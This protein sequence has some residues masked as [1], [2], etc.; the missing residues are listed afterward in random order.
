MAILD[1]IKQNY[2]TYLPYANPSFYPDSAAAQSQ[3]DSTQS[4]VDSLDS[5]TL[6]AYNQ[7][8]LPIVFTGS[9]STYQATYDSLASKTDQELRDGV[10]SLVLYYTIKT[11]TVQGPPDLRGDYTLMERF[12]MQAT[13]PSD[14]NLLS[15]TKIK[16]SDPDPVKWPYST[17]GFDFSNQPSISNFT[18]F[19]EN[20]RGATIPLMQMVFD[21]NDVSNTDPNVWSVSPSYIVAGSKLL[22]PVGNFAD[23][24]PGSVNVLNNYSLYGLKTTI[25]NPG[26]TA[27][28]LTFAENTVLN[29][30]YEGSF[31][32]GNT[33][34]IGIES[35]E[36]SI[37]P[38]YIDSSDST[39]QIYA[40][41]GGVP[42]TIYENRT[43][44][45]LQISQ[46]IETGDSVNPPPGTWKAYLDSYH[47]TPTWSTRVPTYSTWFWTRTISAMAK[48]EWPSVVTVT[49]K[50]PTTEEVVMERN[51]PC[52]S[53]L[54]K[55]NQAGDTAW[56]AHIRDYDYAYD[57][58]HYRIPNSAGTQQDFYIKDPWQ[59]EP[60]VMLPEPGNNEYILEIT[61]P[62]DPTLPPSNNID[63]EWQF[64]IVTVQY[65]LDTELGL[66][67]V[68]IGSGPF[69]NPGE[70]EYSYIYNGVKSG[71]F[72]SIAAAELAM[73]AIVDSVSGPSSATV[74]Q[75]RID[76]IAKL[77]SN[78]FNALPDYA[79]VVN[80]INNDSS[81]NAPYDYY[82]GLL[83]YEAQLG[84]A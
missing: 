15:R 68:N 3:I 83:I 4:I 81:W 2:I 25:Y 84:F 57:Y 13:I 21:Y 6:L 29:S 71:T 58:G 23:T 43:V 73:R 50:D 52:L 70:L 26:S 27:V 69:N 72:S 67:E 20:W 1:D 11:T 51:M 74:A 7:M 10:M 77:D 75:M 49:L 34:T 62:L 40:G 18:K 17:P 41:E 8:Y 35:N 31:S 47:T 24:I 14:S 22:G 39:R 38:D 37:T 44:N 36:T 28:A 48:E 80:Y 9:E 32:G 56:I 66:S 5:A 55:I 16:I 64:P 45:Y 19:Y 61:R 76:A 33:T 42:F 30:G 59:T 82:R 79:T 53:N 12:I 54:V 65:M 78:G 60:Y 46:L 63:P